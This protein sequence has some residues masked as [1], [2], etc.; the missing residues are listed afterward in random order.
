MLL[1]IQI[2]FAQDDAGSYGVDR[3]KMEFSLD[4]AQLALQTF[5]LGGEF[6]V[7]D[8][9][10]I[11]LFAGMRYQ[12]KADKYY[13]GY[14]G[15]LQFRAYVGVTARDMLIGTSKDLFGGLYL[16]PFVQYNNLHEEK[17]ENEVLIQETDYSMFSFGGLVGYK[18]LIGNKFS[19][20]V[21]IAGGMRFSDI[22]GDE[23]EKI[24]VFKPGYKGMFPK[25]QFTLGMQF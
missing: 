2:V 13:M 6:R 10:S 7:A 15:E 19:I 21:N 12:D 17:F 9:S 3:R 5:K 14:T 18:Y 24:N 8:E 1:S 25:G 20:D 16:G 23:P 4:V 11:A 22:S